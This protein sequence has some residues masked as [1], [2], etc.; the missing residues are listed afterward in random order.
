[1][2]EL[3]HHCPLQVPHELH[4]L[5]RQALLGSSSPIDPFRHRGG[6][7][8]PGR[9]LGEEIANPVGASVISGHF[10]SSP[11]DQLRAKAG[12]RVYELDLVSPKKPL[13]R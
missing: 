11:L 13:A 2:Q 8:T 5:P 1:V 6:Y 10:T 7:T 3:W 9:I 12:E 4:Q